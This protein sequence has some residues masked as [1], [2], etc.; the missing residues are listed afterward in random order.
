MKQ[1]VFILLIGAAMTTYNTGNA[2]GSTD[3]RDLYDNAQNFDKLSVGTEMSYQDRLGVERKSWAGL[4]QQVADFL[5]SQ[6]WESVFVQYAANAVVQ[7]PTQLIER[8]GE[9]YRVKLQ[10]DLPLTL[11]GTWATDAPKLV[12]LGNKALRT[13]LANGGTF[14]VDTD[15]VGDENGSVSA[16]LVDLSARVSQNTASGAV[17][18]LKYQ[19]VGDGVADDT[20]AFNALEADITGRPVDLLGRQYLVNSVPLKNAYFNGSFKLP[21]GFTR[22]A[23]MNDTFLSSEP[24]RHIFGGQMA[25][26]M[27]SLSNPLE[28]YVGIVFIGDSITWGSGNGSEMAPTDPRDGT[29]SDP[30][31]YFG[32]PSFVNNFKRY[33]GE[34]YAAGAS[35]IISNWPASTS[36][37]STAEYRQT[38]VMFPRYGDFT[39]T[40]AAGSSMSISEIL[41]YTVIGGGQLRLTSGNTTVVNSHSITFPFTGKAFR[42]YFSTNDADATFYDLLIDGV[43]IGTYSTHAGATATSGTIVDNSVENFN[44]HAFAFKRDAV[45][46][47]RTN[48]NGEAGNRTLRLN[49]I[50]VTKRIVISNQGINGATAK[51]YAAY[52]LSGSFGD[53][54]AVGAEDSYAFV[55][56]GT[57]DRLVPLNSAI[58][59]GPNI[60]QS[61]LK[62]LL[63]AIPSTANK[64]L[65]SGPPTSGEDPAKLWFSMREVRDVI[66]RT[67]KSNSIDMIDNFSA[68]NGADMSVLTVDGVHPN[69]V[70]YQII[71]RNIINSLE[72]S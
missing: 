8:E 41:N 44:E 39:L 19:A 46:E 66:Y 28:Q 50:Q 48:R 49:A 40:Q 60:F 7:R 69:R 54:V 57:N 56:I 36:G 24:K 52:N 61:N 22:A 23:M 2:V 14:L 42:V 37:E 20:A 35:P 63:D 25:K 67:A 34:R 12:A 71:T 33:V 3:A 5:A 27:A 1:W 65:M 38:H 70:G 68:F 26:L 13:E 9:L 21:T 31:D 6:G 15:V 64:I 72:S 4:E 30:R 59:R 45:I 29:L 43:L 32:T 58:A 16:Q 11:T 18:P 17:T 53:G 47:I 55:Q 62:A 10:A 51:S